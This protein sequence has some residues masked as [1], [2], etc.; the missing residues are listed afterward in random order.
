[1]VSV[2]VKH[3]FSYFRLR[4]LSVVTCFTSALSPGLPAVPRAGLADQLHSDGGGRLHQ[5]YQHS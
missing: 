3:H 5:R 2:V 1:M 4:G